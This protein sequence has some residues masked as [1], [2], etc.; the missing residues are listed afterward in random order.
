MNRIK[1]FLLAAACSLFLRTAQN[2]PFTRRTVISGLNSPWE[3]TYGPNDSIWVTENF[4]YLWYERGKHQQQ[5]KHYA[6]Q[7]LR[8]KELCP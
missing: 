5:Q 2:E 4:G 8:A 7:P 3:I 1:R 6:A